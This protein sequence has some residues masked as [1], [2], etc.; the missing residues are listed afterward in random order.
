[1]L[2][3]YA[4]LNTASAYGHFG[5]DTIDP[6]GPKRNV[7]QSEIYIVMYEEGMNKK[8]VEEMEEEAQYNT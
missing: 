6:N 7:S 1:M 5:P 4:T 8:R 2:F 3:T